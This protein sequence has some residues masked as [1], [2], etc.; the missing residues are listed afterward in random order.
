MKKLL[1]FA[2]FAMFLAGG[3]SYATNTR[4]ETMG[5]A[6]NIVK[7]EAN[8]WWYPSTINY[9]PKLVIGEF[10]DDWFWSVGAHFPLAEG[11][12]K[13]YVI[14]AYF[15]DDSYYHSVLYDY[16]KTQTWADQRI[17][18]FYGREISAIPFGFHL[19]YYNTGDKNEDTLVANNY[20]ESLSRYVIGLGISPMQKKLDI[21]I[22]LTMTTW[23]DKDYYN[24]ALGMVDRS[25]PNGNME[26]GLTGRYW[27]GPFGKYMVIPHGAFEIAKQGV[28]WYGYDG[29]AWAVEETNKLSATMIDLGVGINYEAAAKVLVV[30]DMGFSLDNYKWTTDYADAEAEDPDDYKDNYTVLPYF[31]IG[32]DA[33]VLKWLDV[34]CG[35]VKYWEKEKYE[36]TEWQ[37]WSSSYASTDTYLGAGL[38][39]GSLTMD[40]SIDPEFIQNGPYFISG[41]YTSYLMEMVSL[42]Y[43]F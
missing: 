5:E 35:V 41:E 1:I 16:D 31:R 7:D 18:L 12:E 20:E 30:G 15:T 36:P 39:W 10:S 26:F 6:N 32:L 13:P 34:R 3:M 33:E 42:K 38:H 25:K 23:S 21:G 27:W 43:A 24:D 8:I 4:V 22:G 17:D 19:G 37:K 14:G 28:D 9:Y 2:V 29:T 11:S 40:V